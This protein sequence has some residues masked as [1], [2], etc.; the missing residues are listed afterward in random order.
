MSTCA[1]RLDQRADD[2]PPGEDIPPV[3]AHINR[4]RDAVVVASMC[5]VLAATTGK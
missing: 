2:Q 1:H 4:A 3:Y 5:T